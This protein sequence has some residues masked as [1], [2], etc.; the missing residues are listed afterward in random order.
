MKRSTIGSTLFAA[1]VLAVVSTPATAQRTGQDFRLDHFKCYQA[2]DYGQVLDV[3]VQLEDQFDLAAGARESANHFKPLRLCNPVEKRIG[4][5]VNEITPGNENHHLTL[6]A[7]EPDPIVSLNG[8]VLV[9][10]QFGQQKLEFESAFIL[11]VPTGKTLGSSVPTAPD[12]LNHFKCYFVRGDAS[13]YFRIVGLA[14][15][16][17]KT[18][19][20]LLEPVL[21][22]N[23]VRKFVSDGDSYEI[24]D[25]ADEH[26]TCYRISITTTNTRAV[27]I[28]NQFTNGADTSFVVGAAD[29]LCVPTEK[30]SF[31]F[32]H[33]FDLTAAPGGG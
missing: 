15:Q 12:D 29:L 13:K 7:F 5:V 20:K 17:E 8:I 10:N 19:H 11:A 4:N 14:D 22:C 30:K 28:A 6:Y 27:F 21:F 31:T 23:P 16:F 9:S 25:P 1:L 32:H 3:T 26:L 18:R 24:M 2:L 33:I